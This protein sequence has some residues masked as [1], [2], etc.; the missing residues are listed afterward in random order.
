MH[1]STE[2]RKH[3]LPSA[4]RTPACWH[5][6]RRTLATRMAHVA[7]RITTCRN[8]A[9]LHAATSSTSFDSIIHPMDQGKSTFNYMSIGWLFRKIFRKNRGQ[10]RVG[11]PYMGGGLLFR[12]PPCI[13]A[14]TNCWH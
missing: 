6:A 9:C 12:E 3:T 13:T 14:L 7:F 10:W 11:H 8:Q 2:T 4:R 5:N 1:V